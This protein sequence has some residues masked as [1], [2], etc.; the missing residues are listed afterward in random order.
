MSPERSRPQPALE[1]RLAFEQLLDDLS[2]AHVHFRSIDLDLSIDDT[3]RRTCE[4]LGLVH[5]SLIERAGS[6]NARLNFIDER[7]A[8]L[9]GIPPDQHERLDDYWLAHVHPADVHHV[10]TVFRNIE[11]HGR[12]R[13]DVEYRYLHPRGALWF[14]HLVRVFERNAAGE[15]LCQMGVIQDITE[16]RQAE[17]ALHE[18]SGRLI[19]AQE[20]E[21]RRLAKELHDGLSQNLALLAIELELYGQQP[22]QAPEQIAIRMRELSAHTTALS[23]EVHRLSHA[24]HPAKLDQLGLA[25]AIGGFCRELEAGGMLSVRFTARD[26]PRVLPA[27]TTLCLYRVAQEAL[28]NVIKH[29]GVKEATVELSFH[30]DAISLSVSDEGVG[31]DPSAAPPA[32]SLGVVSMRE[33]VRAVNGAI[34]WDSGPSTGATVRVRIPLDRQRFHV[35][36]V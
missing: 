35:P 27:D 29:S 4:A 36:R 25:A 34:R 31:F 22:P 24:L 15:A 9:L 16:R 17:A 23:R 26:V 10:T 18:L 6:T 12:D 3:Q 21:R 5:S 30:G 2:S 8:A 14:R 13:A 7:L 28:Q 19:G 33:R 11:K 20:E 1:E 32:D